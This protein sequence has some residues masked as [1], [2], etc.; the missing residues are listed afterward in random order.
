M[1]NLKGREQRLLH[2]A[3]PWARPRTA[4]SSTF[5]L[6]EV[7]SEQHVNSEVG[8]AAPGGHISAPGAGP[9][10]P[11]KSEGS[12]GLL[13]RTGTRRTNEKGNGTHKGAHQ[14]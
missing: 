9:L 6:H 7:G 10:S 3:Q 2:Q 14:E 1:M 5:L 11:F 12:Q 13:L 8:N 4:A